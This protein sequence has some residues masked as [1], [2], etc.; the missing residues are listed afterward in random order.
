MNLGPKSSKQPAKQSHA[1]EAERVTAKRIVENQRSET[2]LLTDHN[3][4]NQLGPPR[5]F[6]E[7]ILIGLAL[8]FAAWVVT[9]FDTW[10]ANISTDDNLPGDVDRVLRL[11]EIFAHG[12]GLAVMTVGIWTMIP[13]RRRQLPRLLSCAIFPPVTAHIIKVLIG[14]RRPTTYLDQFLVPNFPED[15]STT[16][17]GWLPEATWNINYATQSFP[18]AH[19]ALVCGLAIGMSFLF[20][21]GRWLFVTIALLASFQRVASSAHWM[22]DVLVGAAL[23]FLIAGG[24]VQ[25]WGIGWLCGRLEANQSSTASTGR[26]VN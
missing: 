6:R 19:A 10:F 11:S 26:Q 22:S 5:R 25:N 20:P 24:L 7:N 3:P 8:L 17:I 21:R 18:S 12:F 1:G 9:G 13:A 4:D 16:W 2:N 15:T 23:G 14:R